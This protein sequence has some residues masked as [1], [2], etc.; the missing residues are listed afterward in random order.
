MLNLQKISDASPSPQVA[1]N[2]I[3]PYEKIFSD[4]FGGYHRGCSDKLIC[5]EVGI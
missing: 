1:S 2:N 3:L 4:L 5:D